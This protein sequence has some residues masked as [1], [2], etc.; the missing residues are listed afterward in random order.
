MKKIIKTMH[1]AEAKSVAGKNTECC[2]V[3]SFK[4]GIGDY[5]RTK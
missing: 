4:Q 3:M 5:N 1:V 2:G